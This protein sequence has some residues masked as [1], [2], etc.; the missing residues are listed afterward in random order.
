MAKLDYISYNLRKKKVGVIFKTDRGYYYY[1]CID[2]KLRKPREAKPI[3]SLP[4]EDQ[5]T[6]KEMTAIIWCMLFTPEKLDT[7]QKV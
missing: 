1:Q 7:N 5:R 6:I 4:L 3:Q 2:G